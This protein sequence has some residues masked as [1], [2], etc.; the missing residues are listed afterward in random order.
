MIAVRIIISAKG[1]ENEHPVVEQVNLADHS[2]VLSSD[3][4]PNIPIG[5]KL[6]ARST[7]R[8][9]NITTGSILGGRSRFTRPNQV[10]ACDIT[11]VPLRQGCLYLTALMDWFSWCV[12]SWW[13]TDTMNVE[14][15]CEALDEAL[16]HSRPEIFNTDQGSQFTSRDFTGRPEQASI[17]IS[18]DGQVRAID[19]VMIE[20]LW[21]T[22]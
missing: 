8:R 16:R 6:G 11:D 7:S 19:N 3:L 9:T 12:L 1:R 4:V 10:W 20:Q 18:M 22:V 15:C 14:F 5:L 21:R 17:A 2:R 13:L